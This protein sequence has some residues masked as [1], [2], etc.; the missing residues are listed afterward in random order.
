VFA[1]LLAP[2]YF[3]LPGRRLKVRAASTVVIVALTGY[4][5]GRNNDNFLTCEQFELAGDLPPANCVPARENEPF[6][7][8]PN[9]GR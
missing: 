9:P 8:I 2:D 3:A 5:A 4:L 7:R 6:V 1:R